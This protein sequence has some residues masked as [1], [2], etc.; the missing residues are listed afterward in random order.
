MAVGWRHRSNIYLT[1]KNET[2]DNILMVE[3]TVGVRHELSP[4][5]LL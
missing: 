3:P 2:A 1:E 5:Q 4:H